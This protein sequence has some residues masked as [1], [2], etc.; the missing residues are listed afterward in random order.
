MVSLNREDRVRLINFDEN[1]K[2]I[3]RQAITKRYQSSPPSEREYYGAHE[4]KVQGC[5]FHCSGEAA[6]ASRR[7]I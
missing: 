2:W 3:V 1:A 5:P 7:L 4:F 6:V